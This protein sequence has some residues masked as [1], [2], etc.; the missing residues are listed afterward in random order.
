MVL[1]QSEYGGGRG[2][3]FRMVLISEVAGAR[4][5]AATC[6]RR[7]VVVATAIALALAGR[8]DRIHLMKLIQAVD[9]SNQLVG[10]RL[11]LALNYIK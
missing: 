3:W 7:E 11:Q 9:I 5:G 2:D 10:L 4:L 1:I 8:G 6:D